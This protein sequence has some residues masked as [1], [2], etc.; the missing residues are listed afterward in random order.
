VFAF[1]LSLIL[2]TTDG[3]FSPPPPATLHIVGDSQAC[4]AGMVAGQTPELK[5]WPR[6]KV[7]CKVGT[8][9]KYWEAHLDE[10]GLKAGDSVLVYLGSNDWG[11][12]P[13]PKPVLAKIKA[14]GAKCVWV[15]PPL[16]RGKDGAASKLKADVEKDGACAYLDSRSLNLRQADGVHP[17]SSA[18]HTRWLRAGVAKLSP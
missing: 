10:A 6:V 15:G 11:G 3:D 17:A 14:S 5:A 16:I 13:D 7:T 9:V 12:N 4:G 18:E 2:L 8:P 1:V